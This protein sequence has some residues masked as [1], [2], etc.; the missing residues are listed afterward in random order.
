MLIEMLSVAAEAPDLSYKDL[1]IGEV[2]R[3]NTGVVP[4]DLPLDPSHI[5]LKI[6]NTKWVSLDASSIHR[7]VDSILTQDSPVQRINAELVV[8]GIAG[9]E[10]VEVIV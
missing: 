9:T 5:R 6:N 4:V 7:M 10:E 1:D 8:N 3:F 2:F